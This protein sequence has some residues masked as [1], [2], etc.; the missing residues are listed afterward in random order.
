MAMSAKAPLW[1]IKRTPD[2]YEHWWEFS[3]MHGDQQIAVFWNAGHAQ[4]CA[5][6]LNGN[7]PEPKGT[8]RPEVKR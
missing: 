1:T 7:Q 2:T 8:R 4:D 5:T 6:I 3:L